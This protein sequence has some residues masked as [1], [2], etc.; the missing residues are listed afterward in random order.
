MSIPK[1][2]VSV[3]NLA[4]AR[5]AVKGGCDLLDV[6][7]PT[8][9]PLGMAD[10]PT[11]AEIAAF[12]SQF[13]PSAGPVGCSVALGEIVDWYEGRESPPLPSNIAYA[14]LGPAG[15]DSP[16]CWREGWQRAQSRFEPSRSMR[17]VAVAY[18]DWKTAGSLSPTSILDQASEA[19]CAALL[20]DTQHKNGRSLLDFLTPGEL[21]KIAA[22]ARQNGMTLALAGSLNRETFHALVH[23]RPDVIAVRG[24]AC[25]GNS[26]TAAISSSAVRTLKTTI[27]EM[28]SA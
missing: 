25:E 23:V 20:I 11:I 27:V 4:E 26:R 17:W 18:A 16:Q 9:G 3:R 2:L 24:A 22:D 21:Q 10:A 1:L 7:E 14:K 28:F 12:S 15:I 13:E 6:K 8:R 5:A 19:R